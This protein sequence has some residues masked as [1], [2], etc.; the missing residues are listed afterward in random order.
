[1]LVFKQ[2]VYPDGLHP[3]ILY[4][5]KVATIIFEE[6]GKDF[7]VTSARGGRHKDHSF[8]YSGS[9]VDARRKHLTLQQVEDCHLK[10]T[11]RLGADYTVLLESDHW[12]IHY[13][14]KHLPVSVVIT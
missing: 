2:G 10:L 9:A 5:L 14:P 11:E 13:R 12:H 4:A 6:I 8:H 7:V 1:M 3:E